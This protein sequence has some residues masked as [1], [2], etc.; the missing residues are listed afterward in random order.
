M[1]RSFII[2]AHWHR[3]LAA[4]VLLQVVILAAYWLRP[5]AWP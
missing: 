5:G 3:P 4:L 2:P 1:N